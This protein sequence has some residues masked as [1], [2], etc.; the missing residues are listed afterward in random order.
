MSLEDEV[1]KWS[2]EAF[3]TLEK[4]KQLSSL[5]QAV[6]ESTGHI[7]TEQLPKRLQLAETLISSV[8]NQ[9]AN[10]TALVEH[11]RSKVQ[12]G[13]IGAYSRAVEKLLV[14]ALAGLDKALEQLSAT[15]VPLYLINDTGDKISS[16]KLSDF[17]SHDVIEKLKGNISIYQSNCD[18]TKDLLESQLNNLL[19][20]AHKNN[21]RFS[22]CSKIYESEVSSVQMI[23]RLALS[24]AS[25]PRSNS[26]IVRTIM[27]ENASLEQELVSLL[28]MLTNHYDQ[29]VLALSLLKDSNGN[30]MD[31]DVLR[32]DTLELPSVLK[33]FSSIHDIIMN[34][35]SRAAKFVD[36]KLP[37]IDS[38]INQ[39]EELITS[40]TRFKNEDIVRFVL[41]L[42]KCEEVFRSNSVEVKSVSGKHTVEIYCDVVNQLSFHYNHFHAIYQL[43]YL[44]ELHYEQFVYPRKF[45]KLLNDFLNQNLLQLEE[46]ERQRRHHWLQSYGNFIPKDFVLPGEYNQPSVVQVVSEGLD[47]IQSPT[48]QEDEER[49]LELIEN[50][51]EV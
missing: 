24:T 27:K 35:E 14:P 33:E 18:K 23:M 10:V 22:R 15:T 40:Y 26:N 5:A 29:C 28:E 34:N 1:R 16:Y 25:L 4:A 51:R 11:L 3:H 37:Y 31:F 41:L 46:E 50:L 47:D 17:V 6:L 12:D 20:T 38:V 32:N 45:L 13:M 30:Q 21:S 48:A 44:T 36:Q 8:K 49:L 43:K 39:C 2:D 19:E 9:Q 7:L 42:L